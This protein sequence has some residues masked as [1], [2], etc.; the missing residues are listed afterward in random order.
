MHKIVEKYKIDTDINK[1]F[2]M[3]KLKR[4]NLL[5][6]QDDLK[7]IDYNLLLNKILSDLG[8]E[9]DYKVADNLDKNYYSN[10]ASSA[11][12]KSLDIFDK[13]RIEALMSVDMEI[14]NDDSLFWSTK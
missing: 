10:D 11:L 7:N 14:Y 12:Y 9:G 2:L 5:L 13:Q 3:R 1:D 4:V 8:I 6:R